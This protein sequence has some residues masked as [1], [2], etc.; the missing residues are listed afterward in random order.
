MSA[1]EK[2]AF[3]GWFDEDGLIVPGWVPMVRR[4]TRDG[5]LAAVALDASG[6]ARKN[7]ASLLVDVLGEPQPIGKDDRGMIRDMPLEQV[8]EYAVRDACAA[9]RLGDVL[10]ERLAR[11]EYL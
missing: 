5:Y 2:E 8:A 3:H 9:W 10:R 7:L 6:I 4:R 1:D 11:G